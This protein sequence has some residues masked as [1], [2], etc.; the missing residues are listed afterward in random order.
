MCL[1]QA[2]REKESMVIK[3]AMG[4]KDILIAKKG[5]EATEK[6]LNEAIKVGLECFPSA[7]SRCYNCVI[8]ELFSSFLREIFFFQMKLHLDKLPLW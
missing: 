4:E 6:K 8:A 7:K 5:K 1:L 2:N 3:Y